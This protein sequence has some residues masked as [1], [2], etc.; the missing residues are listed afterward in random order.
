[1]HESGEFNGYK[2]GDEKATLS[3]PLSDAYARKLRHAYYAGISYIDAQ[4]G[5][6]FTELKQLGLDKKYN[7]SVMGRSWLAL[8]R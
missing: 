5:K 3:K 6:V 2:G 1:M 7:Y 8:G 4:I